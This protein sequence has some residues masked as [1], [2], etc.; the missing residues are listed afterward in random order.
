MK[1]RSNTPMDSPDRLNV[2]VD[3][4]KVIGDMITESNLRVDGEVVGN[5]SSAAKV[6]IGATGHIKGNLTCAEA[7]IEGRV[8]GVLKVDGLLTLR[9]NANIEGEISTGKLQVEEGAQF[10]GQ[11]KMSNFIAAKTTTSTSKENMLQE[12]VVY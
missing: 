11:C 8:E 9:S 12:D 7:D 6:V 5:V 10:S 1:K 3:G 4:S 2:I